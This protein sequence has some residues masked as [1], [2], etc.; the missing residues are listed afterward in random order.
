MADWKE[1][2]AA[3]AAKLKAPRFVPGTLCDLCGNAC[4][5]CSWSRKDVQRPVPGWDAVR[6][7]VPMRFPDDVTVWTESYVVLDCPEFVLEDRSAMY[8]ELF[9]RDQLRRKALRGWE[10]EDGEG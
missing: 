7:D 9:D 4:G 1:A 2:L 6:R 10:E 8:M 5:H 3:I